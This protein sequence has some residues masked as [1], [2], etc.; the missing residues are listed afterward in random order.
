MVNQAANQAL[1]VH[2]L[3][4]PINPQTLPIDDSRNILFYAFMAC[5]EKLLNGNF[6]PPKFTQ[7]LLE[8]NQQDLKEMDITY[9][10]D[11]AVHKATNF[12]K[13]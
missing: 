12:I 7:D 3:A 9:Q 5:H 11:M 6:I 2:G 8:I 10:M 4:S 1:K 13:K